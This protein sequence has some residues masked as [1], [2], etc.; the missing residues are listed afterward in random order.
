MMKPSNTSHSYYRCVCN[1]RSTYSPSIHLWGLQHIVIYLQHRVKTQLP[2]FVFR[3][4]IFSWCVLSLIKGDPELVSAIY[5]RGIAYGKKSLQVSYS[6]GI[7]LHCLSWIIKLSL[8]L[9]LLPWMCISIGYEGLFGRKRVCQKHT[10]YYYYLH[11]RWLILYIPSYIVL[12]MF[13]ILMNGLYLYQNQSHWILIELVYSF[14]CLVLCQNSLRIR[15]KTI[16]YIFWNPPRWY[17]GA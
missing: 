10:P 17:L 7:K 14:P 8:K 6:S 16:P 13:S 1:W 12:S 4:I 5:G 9:S 11:G 3:L 2:F 15:F